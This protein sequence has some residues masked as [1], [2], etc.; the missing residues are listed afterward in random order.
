[1][2]LHS[3]CEA[4]QNTQF[5]TYIRES[6]I[7]FPVIEGSHLL[8][9]AAMLGPTLA[10]DL[11]LTGLAWRNEP[12][13]KIYTQF[14]TVTQ[15]GAVLMMSTGVVLFWS[16]AVKCFDSGY[17]RVKILGLFLAAINAAIFHF[18]YYP[19]VKNWD[20][21]PTPPMR[22]RMAGFFSMFIWAVVVL[23]G[24]YTAYTI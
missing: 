5:G 19:T 8:G 21:D 16:E 24:R 10:F 6:T 17:F 22:A 14:L 7:A 13:S 18:G 3:L 11:R 23:T 20:N 1:M 4:L 15:A 12:V 2:D 9:L